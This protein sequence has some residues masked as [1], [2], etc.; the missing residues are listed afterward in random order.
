MSNL[1][2]LLIKNN[3]YLSHCVSYYTVHCYNCRISSMEERMLLIDSNEDTGTL[4]FFMLS[5]T[6]DYWTLGDPSGN[7]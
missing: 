7:Y 4:V 5:L 1:Q 3:S 6:R 2:C